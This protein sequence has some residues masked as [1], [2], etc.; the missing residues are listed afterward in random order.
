M[1][2]ARGRSLIQAR[3][4]S[5]AKGPGS[6]AGYP[7]PLLSRRFPALLLALLALPGAALAQ[8]TGRLSGTVED[9]GGKT[10]SGARVTLVSREWAAV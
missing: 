2:A 9:A 4:P 3:G 1:P 6:F 5:G 8:A 10:I 7:I